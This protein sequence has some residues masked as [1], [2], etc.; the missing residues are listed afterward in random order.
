MR[1]RYPTPRCRGAATLRVML[2]GGEVTGF[3]LD[4]PSTKHLE[5]VGPVAEGEELAD[6]LVGVVSLDISPWGLLR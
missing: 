1:R 5:L 6:A 2:E 4:V 3:E